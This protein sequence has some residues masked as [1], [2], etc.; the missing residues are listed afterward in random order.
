MERTKSGKEALIQAVRVV[1]IHR[2][3]GITRTCIR[4]AVVLVSSSIHI[5]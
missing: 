4:V 3:K 5:V 2:L 1:A